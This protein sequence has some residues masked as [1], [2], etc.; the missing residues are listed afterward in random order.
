[1]SD[2]L[3]VGE[4]AAAYVLGALTPE[5]AHDVESHAATCEHCQQEIADLRGVVS[6]LPLACSGVEPPADLK[7][8]IMAAG[9]GEE[10]AHAVLR[11]AATLTPQQRAPRHD[12]WHRSLPSWAGVAGWMGVATAC[13]IAGMFIGM[14]L[15]GERNQEIPPQS[16]APVAEIVARNAPALKAEAGAPAADAVYGIN[17]QQVHQRVA[18][19]GESE[20]WD[21]SV[22]K[23]GE[24]MPVMVIQP[25]N[26]AHALLVT[27]M[28]MTHDGMVYRV[29]LVRKGKMHNGGV[30]M[31]GKMMK[32]MIPMRVE[33][34]DVIAFS[35]EPPGSNAPPSSTFVMRQT[36]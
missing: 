17:A 25:G 27:D 3:H 7:V 15:S 18:F 9:R 22:G 34:G 1:M 11:R 19:I 13:V 26:T 33:T 29:W 21:L 35:M 16:A 32:T 8:R 12:I 10:E 6:V 24:Q 31:P 23:P 36:L 2:E 28:P 14:G 30:V 4:N 20:V 5:E